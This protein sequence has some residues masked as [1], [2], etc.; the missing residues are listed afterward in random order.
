[1][2][3]VAL[4]V[5]LLWVP[6]KVRARA[7]AAAE[8]RGLTLTM[9]EVSFGFGSVTL[10]D[11]RAVGPG[12][13]ISIDQARGQGPALAL[14]TDGAGAL[15]DMALDGVYVRID[16]SEPEVDDTL[17]ALRGRVNAAA[18][19]SEGSEASAESTRRL[20]ATSVIFELLDQHGRLALATGGGSVRGDHVHSTLETLSF[21][22]EEEGHSGALLNTRFSVARTEAGI[23]LS[24]L[25]IGG[26]AMTWAASAQLAG[27]QG[28]SENS[29]APEPSEDEASAPEGDEAATEQVEEADD[30]EELT[31]DAEE[32][33]DDAEELP[34]REE[35]TSDDTFGRLRQA[36]QTIRGGGGETAQETDDDRPSYLRRLTDDVSVTVEDLNVMQRTESGVASVL[37]GFSSSI[38]GKSDGVFRLRGD[39]HTQSDGSLSWDLLVTPAEANGEGTIEFEKLPLALVT[40]ALPALPWHEPENAQLDGRLTVESTA[41][42]EVRAEGNVT[43]RNGA[44]SAERIAPNPVFLGDIEFDGRA[45]WVPSIR[46]LEVEEA[47]LTM[48]RAR[49][50]IVGSMEDAPDHYLIDMTATLPATSCTDAVGAIPDDLLG[51]IAGFAWVGRFGARVALDVDS[52]DLDNLDLKFQVADGCRFSMVPAPADLRRVRT[53]FTHRVVE[54][55]GSVF[56]MRAGPGSGNWSSIHSIS[57]FM[58]HAVIGHEDGAFLRHSGFSRG[59]IRGSLVRNL[60]A[61]RYVRG[62][63]T[64]TM[65]LAKNLFLKREK[66]LAR[67]VQEVILTWWLESALSKRDILELYLN[68]IEYGPGI[69]GIRNA[70]N[71]YFGHDPAF[72]TPAEA[73]FLACVLPNPKRFHAAYDR[74]TLTGPMLNRTRRFLRHLASRG[75]INRGAL[76]HGLAQLESFRFHRAGQP[77]TSTST[78]SGAARLPFATPGAFREIDPVTATNEDPPTSPL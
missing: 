44:L 15:T 4:V 41:G 60:E 59:A 9:G 65:Q 55:D 36:L 76:S 49:V 70:S 7:R 20:V 28:I 50:H 43:L 46:R 25:S 31:D 26:G 40:P 68:I 24:Q 18:Q 8:R 62:A 30:A 51:D 67:K 63:S 66:T 53:T 72:I 54:P 33:P 32:R 56:E 6:S 45:R 3:A 29:E 71:H 74:G 11:V 73:S 38:E 16:V 58:S 27:F 2:V 64:I 22:G 17:T 75:R 35:V 39:G 12:L 34:E 21:G 61:G 78:P 19:S 47:H 42:A 5:L 23:Q 14:L 10:E 52:R 57:P 48:G 13:M 69:Y 77:P 37:T 1:M